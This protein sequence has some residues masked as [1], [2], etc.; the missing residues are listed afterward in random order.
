MVIGVVIMIVE[1]ILQEV[2]IFFVSNLVINPDIGNL[3][4]ILEE[5]SNKVNNQN[6]GVI[7]Y[8]QDIFI[9]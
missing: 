7:N 1:N 2:R 9:V 3:F 6:I 5:I 4:F 8:E